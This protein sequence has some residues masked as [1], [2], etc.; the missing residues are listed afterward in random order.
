MSGI[1]IAVHPERC[2]AMGL[3]RAVAPDVFGTDDD[4]WVRLLEP[5]PVADR[6]DDVLDAAESC[7]VSAIDVD[8]PP[9]R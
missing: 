1:D 5:G 8:I 6:I 9:R 3:C 2:M 4:G 7:P